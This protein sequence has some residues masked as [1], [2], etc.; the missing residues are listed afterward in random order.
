MS[1]MWDTRRGLRLLTGAGLLLMLLGFWLQG[2]AARSTTDALEWKARGTVDQAF[3]LRVAQLERFLFTLDGLV[4]DAEPVQATTAEAAAS[5]TIEAAV[6]GALASPEAPALASASVYQ[7]IDADEV[8][9]PFVR[10]ATAAADGAPPLA[11]IPETVLWHELEHADTTGGTTSLVWFSPDA[12]SGVR[13]NLAGT[14]MHEDTATEKARLRLFHVSMPFTAVPEVQLVVRCDIL[15]LEA[16][17]ALPAHAVDGNAVDAGSAF[18][19]IRPADLPRMR[20]PTEDPAARGRVQAQGPAGPLASLLLVL[21]GALA[22]VLVYRRVAARLP[23]PE[24]GA[25]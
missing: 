9:V 25:D 1:S 16:T 17:P 3:R 6:Q 19:A 20:W 5:P 13:L 8:T 23:D 21:L 12:G 22:I 24:P 4:L 7:D 15:G 18:D 2:R 10:L 14:A 11:A